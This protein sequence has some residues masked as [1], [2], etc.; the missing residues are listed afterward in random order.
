MRMYDVIMKKRDGGI[1]TKEEIDYFVTEY[2]KGNIPDYQAS[3]LTM[4]IFFR[5]MCDEETANLTMAMA[6]SGD[7]MKL[8]RIKGIKVDKH[9]TGGVGDKT[10]LVLGPMV[11]ALDIPVAKMSGRGLGHTGGT[12]DKL[13]SFPGFVTGIDEDTFFNNVNDIHI[14]IAGQTG[15]L[16]PADKKLY[17]LR[18]VTATVENT[19]LI[20]SSIMSKK[21]AAGADVIVLDVKTGSGAFMKNDK[22]ALELAEEMVNIGT[23]VGRRTMAVVSNM[24]QPLGYA[25]GNALEVTEAIATLDGHG[26]E[27]LYQLCLELGSHMVVGAG[28]TDSTDK[29]K[30]MLKGVIDDKSA[31][32]RLAMLVHGQ[33]GD[34]RAVYDTSLLPQ[35]SITHEVKADKSGYVHQIICDQVGLAAMVMGGGRENKDSVIDLG[36]GI[37]L[38]K[39][40]GDCVKEGET[41]AV[42]YANDE[43]KLADGL[44]RFEGAYVIEDEECAK[45]QL[46]KYIV[47]STGVIRKERN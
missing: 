28:V 21:I 43:K 19:S 17:A 27:D 18:D 26:P 34:E 46:I 7:V 24:D 12:I 23:N 11:A 42:F 4:A 1:L 5:G 16:A 31:L 8:D 3:A 35:A 10:S 32:K 47:T 45:P 30:A 38:Q 25:V 6:Q 2:T 29:A 22:A 40:V 14:A 44:K 33:H 9:S 13:E 39:K 37:V 15:N 20:A 41:L 36:V